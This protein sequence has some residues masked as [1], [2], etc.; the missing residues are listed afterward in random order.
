MLTNFPLDDDLLEHARVA[1]VKERRERNFD[2]I[3]YFLELFPSLRRS[4]AEVDALNIQFNRYQITPLHNDIKLDADGKD[5]RIDT[6]WS[7]L[8]DIQDC[9]GTSPF[10]ELS[11]VMLVILSLF[12]ANSDCERIFSMVRKTK[13]ELKGRLEL[14][15]LNALLV[16]KVYQRATNVDCFNYEPTKDTLKACKG[17][18]KAYNKACNIK[19]K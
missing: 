17:A 19:A 14:G 6:I 7:N 8:G 13:S 16:Q 1:N 3:M 5:L 18:T 9:D 11:V 2:S 10:K 15:S 12:H 4:P